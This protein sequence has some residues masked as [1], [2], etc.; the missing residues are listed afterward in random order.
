[1]RLGVA[2]TES[3]GAA[4]R[5]SIMA[6][7]YS[8]AAGS[9]PAIAKART[10]AG[11]DPPL[12][13]KA[14][15]TSSR[16]RVGAS[17]PRSRRRRR[18]PTEMPPGQGST[19]TRSKSARSLVRCWASEKERTAPAKE[20]IAREAR[21]TMAAA[22]ISAGVTAPTRTR[23]ASSTTGPSVESLARAA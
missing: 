22:R 8:G 16:N 4:N 1:M 3:D 11:G 23:R 17:E 18:I 15:I 5:V 9:N 10:P 7:A 13:A 14:S 20:G 12:R 21:R 6:L 19:A 2:V